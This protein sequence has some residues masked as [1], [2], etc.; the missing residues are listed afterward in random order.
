M[1]IGIYRLYLG[2]P[3][4]YYVGQSTNITKRVSEHL[5]SL[6][7]NSHYNYKLQTAYNISKIFEHVLLLECSTEE[8]CSK[9][10]EKIREYDSNNIGY[11]I[12][13]GGLIN[14]SGL[15]SSRSK[16]TKEEIVNVFKLCL[17]PGN[18]YLKISK[19]TG[20]N[21]YTVED[22]AQCR[23]HT[24]LQE[25]YAKEYTHLRHIKDTKLRLSVKGKS[26]SYKYN[27]LQDPMGTIFSIKE[28]KSTRQF[29]KE[30]KLGESSI[31]L[32]LRDKIPSKAYKGWIAIDRIE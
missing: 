18:S 24:W 5:C 31:S 16:Y 17:E 29:C 14:S 15:N 20:V 8:L 13:P 23:T 27:K 21:Y 28:F 10:Y 19:I 7:N 11:N 25:E 1:N 30:H 2:E 4:K 26:N 12:L 9:E 32:L 22:I 3:N 6:K